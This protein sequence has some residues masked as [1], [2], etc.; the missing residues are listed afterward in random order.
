MCSTLIITCS[1]F[2]QMYLCGFQPWHLASHALTTAPGIVD[3]G[4]P[5]ISNLSMTCIFLDQSSFAMGKRRWTKPAHLDWLMDL[6]SRD[7]C[8]NVGVIWPPSTLIARLFVEACL[9]IW[10]WCTKIQNCCGNSLR[11][12]HHEE[13]TIGNLHQKSP[14]LQDLQTY[15]NGTDLSKT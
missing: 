9:I 15:I 1:W 11:P 12:I 5:W 2:M 8:G 3:T 7:T 13:S 14:T 4:A 6:I 10:S